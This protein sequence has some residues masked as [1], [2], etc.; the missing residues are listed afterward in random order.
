MG[1]EK[2]QKSDLGFGEFIQLEGKFRLLA[3]GF[4]LLSLFAVFW[5]V[6]YLCAL[7]GTVQQDAHARILIG[8]LIFFG[9][10]QVFSVI[11]LNMRFSFWK[12]RKKIRY[13][14]LT[15][16]LESNSFF[17]K[18]EEEI[19]RAGRYHYPATLCVLDIDNF[20]AINK[21]NGRYYAD[22][23]LQRFAEIAVSHVR[24]SDFVGRMQKDDFLI[25]LSHTDLAQAEK[26]LYRLLLQAQERLDISF[27]VGLTAYRQGE[28]RE[29]FIRRA[30]SALERAQQEGKKKT[31]CVICKDDSR[32]V[33]NFDF[34]KSA[35]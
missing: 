27:S 31:R 34:G 23:L 7:P 21:E 14:S 8:L 18:L 29:E 30:Q 16:A 22:E 33:M 3:T 2:D 35:E 6:R 15:C 26:F 5:A 20:K 32:V 25:L 24:T 28:A 11:A 13:D 4:N 12:V 17:D 10:A 1:T 9:A 19:R